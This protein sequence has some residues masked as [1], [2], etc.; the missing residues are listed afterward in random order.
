MTGALKALGTVANVASVSFEQTN[1]ALQS[2]STINIRGE[3]AGTMFRNMLIKMMSS[4]EDLN[5]Q[6]V[7][8]DKALENLGNHNM[9]TAE[10]GKMFGTENVVAAQHLVSDRDKV[11][12][13]TKALTG[14]IEAYKMATI[15]N[16][17]LEFKQKQTSSYAS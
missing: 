8:L 17:T 1:G 15:N 2:L 10:L 13:F 3:Q 5:P 16:D 4:S 9:T 11:T 12:E 14:T 6:I 7:G